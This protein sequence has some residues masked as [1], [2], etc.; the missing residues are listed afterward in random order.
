MDPLQWY[1][2]LL[3]GLFALA[4]SVRGLETLPRV[5]HVFQRTLTQHLT[6]AL[7]LGHWYGVGPWTRATLMRKLLYIAVNLFFLLYQTRTVMSAGHKAGVL[8]TVNMIPL[9]FSLHHGA[10]ADYLGLS[11]STYR[12][13]HLEAALMTVL[14]STFHTIVA[15]FEGPTFSWGNKEN[16]YGCIVSG[17][18]RYPAD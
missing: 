7:V 11:L 17:I 6:Y 10:M 15:L 4:I 12:V 18:H 13:L 9:Y 16:L 3:G 2:C 8:A 1:A 5:N 14:M